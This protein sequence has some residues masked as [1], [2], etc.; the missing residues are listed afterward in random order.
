[1]KF[2][3]VRQIVVSLPSYG[4][5][6]FVGRSKTFEQAHAGLLRNDAVVVSVNDR[7]GVQSEQC[8]EMIGTLTLHTAKCERIMG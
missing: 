5:E 4:H 6:T 7:D 2:C 8:V 1:M 3:G